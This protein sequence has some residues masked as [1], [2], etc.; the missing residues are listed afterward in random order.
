M[1]VR[2]RG[3]FGGFALIILI[4][5]TACSFPHRIHAEGTPN[6][7]RVEIPNRVPPSTSEISPTLTPSPE[8][9]PSGKVAFTCQIS[10]NMYQDQICIINAD[11]TGFTRLTADDD[12]EH[13]YPS[14]AP[15][16]KSVV[17]SANLTGVYEIYEVDLQGNSR[18]LTHGLGTLTAPE[19]SP[20]GQLI[21]FTLGNGQA[22]SIWITNKDGNQPR[23]V[24]GPGWDPTWS[25]DGK[26]LMFASYAMD[27]SIQLF[28]INL[29]GTGL[30]QLTRMANLRGR[31][32]WSPDGKWAVTYAGEPWQREL[33]LVPVGGGDP[34]QL[35]PAG[36]N[37]QGPSF[38]PDGLWV[39]FTAYFD[40]IGNDNGCE[41]Y[42]IRT[43]GTQLTR[44]TNN[45]YCDWQPR[46]GP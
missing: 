38:S 34:V 7:T 5:M 43:D 9:T 8:R 13:F 25:P 31:S 12:F 3:S 22:T 45:A 46:W 26:K 33:Y 10:G 20:D 11:G 27:N 4:F 24:Y 17:Y 14:V 15:D 42:E 35:T 18:Q 30:E 37:S 19:I 1:I 2:P 36:G 28:T 40:E 39:V 44:L 41:I 29:E 6:P 32:D 16:G 21:A 23:V